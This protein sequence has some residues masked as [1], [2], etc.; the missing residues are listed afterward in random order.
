MF[1]NAD[2][3]K[4]DLVLAGDRSDYAE[5]REVAFRAR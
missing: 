1:M 5:A 3:T 4:F 2:L